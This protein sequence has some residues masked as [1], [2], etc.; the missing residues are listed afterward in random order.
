MT[1]YYED[2][3]QTQMRTQLTFTWTLMWRISFW[4]SS[5]WIYPP[6]LHGACL[7]CSP[8]SCCWLKTECSVPLRYM[9]GRVSYDQLNAAVQSI[10]TAVAAKYKILHQS[11]KTLNNHARKLYQRFKDQETKDTKGMLLHLWCSYCTWKMMIS[12]FGSCN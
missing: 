4:V 9:K 2:T 7:F 5:K 11:A 3:Q 12:M 10:N 6:A 8:P 1:P